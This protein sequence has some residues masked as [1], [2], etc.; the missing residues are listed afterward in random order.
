M[1][2]CLALECPGFEAIISL[3]ACLR[4]G[5]RVK[6]NSMSALL[7]SHS[8]GRIKKWMRSLWKW[9]QEAHLTSKENEQVHIVATYAAYLNLLH[10]VLQV[11]QNIGCIS[12]S[13]YGYH[14]K[15]IEKNGRKFGW[16]IWKG[17]GPVLLISRVYM[18]GCGAIGVWTVDHISMDHGSL[19]LWKFSPLLVKHI[20]LFH[21]PFFYPY[22]SFPHM[23]TSLG[24]CI[25]ATVNWVLYI[26]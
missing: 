21:Q 12:C 25:G 3:R 5:W 20:I 16:K 15:K 13:C 23:C 7:L 2:T 14:N 6:E 4:E 9:M 24:W 22:F 17:Y 11:W 10:G 19:R 8:E 18:W 1:K 26:I